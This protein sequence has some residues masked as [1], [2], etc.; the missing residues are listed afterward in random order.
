MNIGGL[1]KVS[2]CD[3]PG[4]VSAVIF[5]RGCNFNCPFCHNQQLIPMNA[6]DDVVVDDKQIWQYLKTRR[7]QLDGL[8]VSG[9]EPSLQPDLAE[10]LQRAK[11]LGYTIKLDTNGSRPGVLQSL[12][13]SAL[14]DFIAMDVKAP[15]RKYEHLAGCRI[16]I[17]LIQASIKLIL[18]SKL[19]HQFRTTWYQE[20]LTEDDL[21]S[22]KTIL[23]DKSNYLFQPYVENGASGI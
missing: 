1:Q 8:V 21:D 18:D 23:P 15:W 12:I 16:D 17:G 10:F 11:A 22:I 6:A 3:F 19:P 7:N 14:V 13:A 5:T 9:G 20:L 2:F 4:K